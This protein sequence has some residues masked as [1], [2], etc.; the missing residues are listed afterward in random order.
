MNKLQKIL[1]ILGSVTYC[2]FDIIPKIV[3]I[4]ESVSI[5]EKGHETI[6]EM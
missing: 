2:H 6:L 3:N 4:I 1:H 5:K